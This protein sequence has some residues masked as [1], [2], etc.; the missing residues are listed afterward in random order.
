[1]RASPST[2][3]LTG[4]RPDPASHRPAS[5][6]GRLWSLGRH[7]LP[8][9]AVG[10]ATDWLPE[11]TATCRLRG[12]LA[13]RTFGACGAGFALGKHFQV[14]FPEGLSVGR[15][16]YVARNVWL[17]AMGGV[18]LED[19]VVVGPY[20][21][22]ASTNHRFAGGTTVNAGSAPAPIRIGHGSWL[23]ARVVVTAGVTIGSGVL[24]AAGAVVTRDVPDGAM[25][26]GVPARVVRA[27][28]DDSSARLA[29]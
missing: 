13:G 18:T 14:N 3:A 24:V 12:S 17:Q 10:L 4:P 29:G 25:V 22:I 16:C 2:T 9:W 27:R 28:S 1:M 20:A 11:N 5:L 19:E 7:A 15:R 8:L 21:V 23:G 6:R 26:A